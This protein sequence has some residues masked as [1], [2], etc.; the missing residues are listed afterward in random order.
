MTNKKKRAVLASIS[1]AH[2]AFSLSLYNIKAHLQSVEDVKKHWQIDVLQQPLITKV[3]E[4]R[5]FKNFLSGLKND[6]D[7]IAFSCYMWGIEYIKDAIQALKK[8][9]PKSWIVVGGPEISSDWIVEGRYENL[10][11]DIFVVG[12]GE[13]A[14]ID[15]LKFYDTRNGLDLSPDIYFGDKFRVDKGLPRRED[16]PKVRL[17]NREA[18]E[19]FGK[20][21]MFAKLA[22]PYLSGV[23]DE[24]V[25]KRPNIQANIETQRGCSLK[26]TYCIYHKDMPKIIYRDPS[27]VLEEAVFLNSKGVEKLRLTDANFGSS[28]PFAKKIIKGFIVKNLKFELMLE[29]IP[30]FIDEELADLFQEFNSLHKKNYISVGLGVQ[31]INYPTLKLIRRG[32]KI[33]KFDK[34]FELLTTRGIYCK[35]DVIVGLPNETLSMIAQTQ[36]YML[37]KLRGSRAHLLCCHL[38]RGIPGS[39]LT[40][41]CEEYGLI[42]SSEFE[43]YELRHSPALPR[44]DL[45]IALR[46]TAVIFRLINNGFSDTHNLVAKEKFYKL[47]KQLN[48]ENLALIDLMIPILQNSVPKNSW[49]SNEDFPHSETWWWEKSKQEVSDS[50][51]INALDL[52]EKRYNYNKLEA[53]C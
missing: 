38:L 12:E 31:S 45:L 28:L 6:Y 37:E 24:E 11:A 44:E 5:E 2:N 40:R 1:G 33:E 39:E 35:I 29:L 4:S 43:P 51:I 52:I 20:N 7:V 10:L 32:V 19:I 23:V 16:G 53:I 18:R 50:M 48:L 21:N 17:T 8:T 46:R 36:E 22:S 42:F 30:G 27:I 34:T 49:F 26:C 47:C 15:I 13:K 25:L 9:N 41:T 3:N 14:F